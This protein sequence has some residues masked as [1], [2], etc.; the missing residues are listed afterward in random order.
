MQGAVA[1]RMGTWKVDPGNPLFW[2][3]RVGAID[4]GLLVLEAVCNG[5]GR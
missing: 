3:C 2:Q 1:D 4:G 5:L